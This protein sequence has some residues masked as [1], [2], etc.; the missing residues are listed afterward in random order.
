M[1]KKRYCNAY[2]L[3][4]HDWWFC[5]TYETDTNWIHNER[6]K[7]ALIPRTEC[8]A[9]SLRQ[10][11]FF[12]LF[13]MESI[14]TTSWWHDVTMNN[15]TA[16]NALALTAVTSNNVRDKRLRFAAST[17]H[18]ATFPSF[19]WGRKTITARQDIYWHHLSRNKWQISDVS[20][21]KAF[22]KSKL[23]KGKRPKRFLE[24]GKR[25]RLCSVHNE[26]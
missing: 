22:G 24:D 18:R 11:K 20:L 12:G 19:C 25:G 2:Y 4:K 1:H 5:L 6:H 13:L 26:K 7:Q 9:A 3:H 10:C 17:S 15:N 16:S 8:V 14:K 21:P 23:L